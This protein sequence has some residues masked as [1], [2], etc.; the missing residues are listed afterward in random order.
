MLVILYRAGE[1][2]LSISAYRS[3][4]VKERNGSREMAGPAK[5]DPPYVTTE[6][7]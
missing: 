4:S 5:R 2:D 1:S 3:Y 6:G 7:T